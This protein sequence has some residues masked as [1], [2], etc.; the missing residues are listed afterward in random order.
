MLAE[1]GVANETFSE[2]V[3]ESR[4]K[5]VK[6]I[7][8]KIKSSKEY[9]EYAFKRMR[10]DMVFAKEGTSAK[11]FRSGKKYIA[12]IIARFLT[13]RVAKLYA[14]NPKAYYTK[15][16]RRE[17]KYWDGNVATIQKIIEKSATMPLDPI[18]VAMVE[19]FKEGMATTKLYE[20]MGDTLVK[21]FNYYLK[22]QKP[23]FKTQMK[24]LVRRSLTC[25]VGYIKLGYQRELQR[26]SISQA[27][28][29]DIT[30]RLQTI[31]RISD[32]MQ[33]GTIE[34]DSAEAE[35]LK[36]EL[37][38]IR[39]DPES[40]KV[41]REGL[42]FD[43]PKSTSI[44]VCKNCEN[45]QGFIG[46]SFVAHEIFFEVKEIKEMYNLD[47]KKGNFTSYS[48]QQAQR[49]GA[50]FV[51]ES[52]T[53]SEDNDSC[54]ACLYEFYCKKT[55][56]VY[57]V[58]EGYDDFVVEPDV[59]NIKVEGFF[60]IYALI[61]NGIEDEKEI[62]PKSDVRNI[63][64]MQDEWNRSREGLREHRQAARPRYISPRGALEDDDKRV[65]MG[66]GAHQVAEVSMGQ[67]TKVE[68]LIQPVP[69]VGVDPNLYS[70]DHLMQDINIV[71]GAQESSFSSLS[72]ATATEVTDAAGASMTAMESN[73]DE[74]NDFLTEIARDAGQVLMLNASEELVRSIVG[75][76][77]VWPESEFTRD[78]VVKELHIDIEA[79]SSGKANK[80][81][82]LA[83]YERINPAMLQIPGLNKIAWLKE[84]IKRLDDKLDPADFIDENS[85]SIVA[86]NSLKQPVTNPAGIPEQQGDMGGQNAT[87]SFNQPQGSVA[88]MGNNQI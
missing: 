66:L 74:M 81:Q 8:C 37:E 69:S 75:E 17:Y 19:D 9:H 36:I 31:Q 34:E 53:K 77:A 55:G 6:E 39:N 87:G 58:I 72:G 73:I 18:D 13:N 2:E 65:L 43:F 49:A 10:E 1:V 28:I 56:L 59:P 50:S 38:Q 40:M 47:L 54:Y 22:E 82:E 3:P 44:I 35:V 79:G 62:Y 60:P 12:N 20:G 46:A 78:K 30:Q 23:K 15:T 63:I 84:G 25:G 7:L 41:I 80:A 64:H 26:T 33:D 4:K 51:S 57:T 32:G 86:L 5:L 27:K 61:F 24:Q 68:E 83:N 29:D 16:P 14:K 45:L 85:L 11:V 48:R 70:T 52:E 21:L 67:S 71:V 88:P 42:I 76:G